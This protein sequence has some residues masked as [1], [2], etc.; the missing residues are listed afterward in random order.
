MKLCRPYLVALAASA[1]CWCAPALA[2][3]SCNAANQF[4]FAFSS[5]PTQTLNYA[6]NYNYTASN[7]LAQTRTFNMSFA[8]FGTSST[9]VAGN[10]M[11]EISNLV[12]GSTVV[13]N[14]VFGAIFTGRTPNV[15]TNNRVIVTT[16]TFAQPVREF[17]M[18]LHDVDFSSNQFRDIIQVLGRNGANTYTA[19]L[20][21]QWGNNNQGGSL[22]ATNSSV[23]F[24]PTGT[25]VA[26][27]VDQAVGTGSS[28]NNSDT[29]NVD[30]LFTQPVTSVEIRYANAPLTSGESSTGQQAIGIS[31][32]SFCPMPNIQVTKSSAPVAVTGPERF[33]IPGAFVDYTL[34]VTNSGGSTVDINSSLLA[35]VLPPN[36][37]F[38]N[39]DINTALPGTQN[40]VF[41]AGTS[42]LSLTSGN[43]TYS[44][45]GGS[46]Y[47]YS[48]AAGLDANVDA[49]RFAPTGT[50]AANSSFTVRFRARIN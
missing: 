34:T 42:G 31:R 20:S 18:Y 1:T 48:P 35:D 41:T 5:R 24:G 44:N 9:V 36:V 33:N 39:G 7:T 29:G 49:I 19:N 8:T 21:S 22:T 40:F 3:T 2:Q 47:G 15:A 38:Y 11:P 13:N 50:F 32:L 37:T 12:S 30:L 27:T 6:N 45:N 4:N 43:I 23:K 26:V 14:L 10:Q 25:P 17:R 16:F 28:G 46:T